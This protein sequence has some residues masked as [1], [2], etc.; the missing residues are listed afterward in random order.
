[1]IPGGYLIRQTRRGTAV[2]RLGDVSACC[3]PSMSMLSQIFSNSCQYCTNADYQQNQQLFQNPNNAGNNSGVPCCDPSTGFF[4]ALFSNTCN[5]CD[6]V[7][8]AVGLATGLPQVPG[9]VWLGLGGAGLLA[10][11]FVLQGGPRR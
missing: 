11:L 2:A 10:A 5:L 7:G 3:D 8:S 6:P 1:M 9:W 4:S